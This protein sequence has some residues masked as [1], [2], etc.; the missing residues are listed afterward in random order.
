MASIG[1]T[2]QHAVASQTGYSNVGMIR[3]EQPQACSIPSKIANA[4]GEKGL[5][6]KSLRRAHGVGLPLQI[7][8][9]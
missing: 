3:T 6:T 2:G 5:S 1:E 7:Y 4:V 8:L 9:T